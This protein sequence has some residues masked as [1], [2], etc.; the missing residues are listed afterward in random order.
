ML[1]PGGSD[2]TTNGLISPATLESVRPSVGGGLEGAEDG[3]KRSESGGL[4]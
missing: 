2:F 3:E 1:A 4:I